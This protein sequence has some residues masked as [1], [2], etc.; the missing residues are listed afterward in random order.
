MSIIDSNYKTE[1]SYET[2]A[3]A[4]WS[5]ATWKRNY[6]ILSWDM[7]NVLFS[8]EG[9]NFYCSPYKTVT[10]TS[11]P[12]YLAG[13]STTVKKSIDGG[14][15]WTD[16]ITGGTNLQ[17]IASEAISGNVFVVDVGAGTITAR[18]IYAYD[19]N[20]NLIDS[21]TFDRTAGFS[22]TP[23][24][25]I[26]NKLYISE[27]QPAGVVGGQ[28][29]AYSEWIDNKF[30]I[31]YIENDILIN[32]VVFKNVPFSHRENLIRIMQSTLNYV[33]NQFTLNK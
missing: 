13:N 31:S 17:G 3:N 8:G 21:T 11:F 19:K 2:D 22:Q 27:A 23:L 4:N 12:L 15:N 32:E 29:I 16:F 1:Y 30:S 33:E 18:P 25:F 10:S 24:A 6:V 9:S 20:G 5:S 28:N 26:G 14:V 7:E